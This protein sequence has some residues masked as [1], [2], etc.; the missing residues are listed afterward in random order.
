LEKKHMIRSLFRLVFVTLLLSGWGLAALSLHVVRTPSQIGLIPKQRLGFTDTYVDARSWTL[1]DLSSHPALVRRVLEAHLS[2][3][4]AYLADPRGGPVADQL[5]AVIQNA[6]RQPQG[7]W[8]KA[9]RLLPAADQAGL[10][11]VS[12]PLA[13]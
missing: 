13:F 10:G 3:L 5:A 7:V 1:D 12:F 11:A 2:N 9:R 8:D 4:F 6:P